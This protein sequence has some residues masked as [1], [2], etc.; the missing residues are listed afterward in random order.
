M[1]G[2][3]VLA[4]LRRVQRQCLGGFTCAPAFAQLARVESSFTGAK[5]P[6]APSLFRLLH[7]HS[8][9]RRHQSKTIKSGTNI[10]DLLTAELQSH[11]G[12]LR[13]TPSARLILAP[14]LLPEADAGDN[15]A[16]IQARVQGFAHHLLRNDGA[17]AVG[18]L[19]RLVDEVCSANGESLA[20]ERLCSLSG[21]TIVLAVQRLP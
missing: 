15:M 16:E 4:N 14:K 6:C 3:A 21:T 1:G 18:E 20:T 8:K 12:V 13:A 11:L 7:N 2:P 19:I 17:L 9:D 5:A 10:R